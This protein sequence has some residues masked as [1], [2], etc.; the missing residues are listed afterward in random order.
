MQQSTN[1]KQLIKIAK[2]LLNSEQEEIRELIKLSD[3]NNEKIIPYFEEVPDKK[4]KLKKTLRQLGEIVEDVG[5][6]VGGMLATGTLGYLLKRRA[7]GK[8]GEEAGREKSPQDDKLY[9]D[10]ALL[11]SPSFRDWYN[12]QR[13]K[14]L[15]TNFATSFTAGMIPIL[16]LYKKGL[17]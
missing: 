4:V 9:Y 7:M 10:R 13:Y 17:L 6:L 12:K 16:L 5:A 15:A 8:F 11:M 14:T 3:E 1:L 2:T